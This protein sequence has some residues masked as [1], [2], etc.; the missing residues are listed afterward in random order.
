MQYGR[1]DL[2]NSAVSAVGLNAALSVA[3]AAM[4][5]AHTWQLRDFEALHQTLHGQ[6]MCKA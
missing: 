4:S 6:D 2:E 1:S 5:M 3:L